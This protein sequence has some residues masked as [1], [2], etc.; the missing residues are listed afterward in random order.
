LISAS[1]AASS[2]VVYFPSCLTR[3]LG[4]SLWELNQKPLVQSVSSLLRM[5]DYHEAVPQ[6]LEGLCCGLSFESKGHVEAGLFKLHEL[7]KKLWEVSDEGRRPVLFDTSPCFV[8]FRENQNLR[9]W[10]AGIYE[11]ACFFA[12]KLA[13]R[14]TIEKLSTPLLYHIPCSAQKAGLSDAYHRAASLLS[15]QP[16]FMGEGCCGFAGDKGLHFPELPLSA[17]KNFEGFDS[18]CQR[19]VSGSATCEMAL[20][21]HGRRPFSSILKVAEEQ[22]KSKTMQ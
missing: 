13:P 22:S 3:T 15:G 16:T 4:P 2:A 7:E 20:S 10:K 19:G 11:P 21:A 18:G 9:R 8:R 5:A 1:S 14:L 6:S 12:D 17:V